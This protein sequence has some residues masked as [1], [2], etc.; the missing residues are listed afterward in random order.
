MSDTTKVRAWAESDREQAG[1]LDWFAALD[2]A[3][4]DTVHADEQ[5][6]KASALRSDADG[7]TAVAQASEDGVDDPE[8]H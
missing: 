8:Q 1:A 7:W 2:D 6:A 3:K 5:R 4:G